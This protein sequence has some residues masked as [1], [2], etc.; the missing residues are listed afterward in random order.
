MLSLI[1][2][3][4]RGAAASAPACTN[5]NSGPV[6]FQDICSAAAVAHGYW[7]TVDFSPGTTLTY[8]QA[9]SA[10]N[11]IIATFT[12]KTATY[13]PPVAPAS[14]PGTWPKTETCDT[15]AAHSNAAAT[16]DYPAMGHAF[17]PI[18]D[19]NGPAFTAAQTFVGAIGCQ[20]GHAERTGPGRQGHGLPS[21]PSA[22]CGKAQFA[23]RGSDERNGRH[24]P[25]RHSG[26]GYRVQRQQ[27]RQGLRCCRSNYLEFTPDGN[28]V[29]PLSAIAPAIS[30]ILTTM[31]A[32][33]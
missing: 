27:R 30:K 6:Q 7:M 16:I 32:G 33:G 15:F 26:L 24:G 4:L 22:R 1:P 29:L 9:F 20:V 14:I 21:V 8:A 18:Y 2:S 19:S 5:A 3:S 11:A 23:R 13:A 28:N 31:N 12:A 25:W 17:D 10:V